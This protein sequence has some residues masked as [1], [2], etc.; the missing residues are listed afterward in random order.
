METFFSL[1]QGIVAVF[2]SIYA[3]GFLHVVRDVTVLIL[4]PIL[5]AIPILIPIPIPILIPI[6][7][8]ILILTSTNYPNTVLVLLYPYMFYWLN[9]DC[10]AYSRERCV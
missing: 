6:P 10:F 4:I 8:P 2:V 5:I 7:I 3:G 1:I 9:V